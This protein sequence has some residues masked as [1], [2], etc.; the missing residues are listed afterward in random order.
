MPP[1]SSQGKWFSNPLSPTSSISDRGFAAALREWWPRAS[2]PKRTLPS[3]VAPGKQ[4]LVVFLKQQHQI[5]GGPLTSWPL[6]TTRPALG[7]NQAR[8]RHEQRRLAAA[9]WPDERNKLAR[10]D[11]AGNITDRHGRFAAGL[12]VAFRKTLNVENRHGDE[13]V[14]VYRWNTG[15]LES[16]NHY[17]N[18]PIVHHSR[19]F[20]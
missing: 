4:R 10:F 15:V 14:G 9:G 16:K 1:E 17:S 7:V 12:P 8:D 2:K 3:T 11:L 5:G 18:T 6:T 20:L 13:K 19:P